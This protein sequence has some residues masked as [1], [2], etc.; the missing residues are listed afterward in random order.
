MS[1][2]IISYYVEITQYIDIS[3]LAYYH[4]NVETTQKRKIMNETDLE[5]FNKVVQTYYS[6]GESIRDTAKIMDISRTKV[7]KILITMGIIKSEITDKALPLI[8]KGMTLKKVSEK[9]NISIATLSTYLPYGNRVNNR[10]IKTN[11]AI[12]SKQYKERQK[13][14]AKKQV[15]KVQTIKEDSHMKKQTVKPT[16]AYVLHL[17]LDKTRDNEILKKYGKVNES[18]SR[19]IIVPE[20]YNLHALHYAIQK[21]FGWQ[22]SHLHRYELPQKTMLKVTSDSFKKYCEL[23][24]IYFRFIYDDY[25]MDD[26]YWDDD[27]QEGRSF[28]TWL[29]KKYTNPDNYKGGLEHYLIAQDDVK[30]FW[31]EFKT[32]KKKPDFS[33]SKETQK[34]EIPLNKATYQDFHYDFCVSSGELLERLSISELL[35]FEPLNKEII[36]KEIKNRKPYYKDWENN[37]NTELIELSDTKVHPVTDT[38]EYYYDYGDSWKVIIKLMDIID[39]KEDMNLPVCI[40]ADGLPVLDD[41]GGVSGYEDFLSCVRGNIP[42]GPYEEKQDSLNWARWIGWTGRINKAEKML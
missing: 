38:I 30:D 22:N 40:K 42:S 3:D 41:V 36:D 9:L 6:T 28:K 4:I 24:G 35:T 37:S 2:V 12:R 23:C 25:M 17:E 14:A 11:D 32:I 29:K 39:L 7:R 33:K 15:H 20:N 10:E 8:Q 31:K 1:L 16:K 18:I 13:N 21:L 19:D 34:E 5:Y 26:I 27:Y